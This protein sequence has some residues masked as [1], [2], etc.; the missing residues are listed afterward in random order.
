MPAGGSRIEEAAAG[1]AALAHVAGSEE[2]TS[3]AMGK[4][5][6]YAQMDELEQECT[7]EL[8]WTAKGWDAGDEEPF[9]KPWS[10][11]SE[12]EQDAATTLGFD[13]R[14]FAARETADT[15]QQLNGGNED[16]G[17][18]HEVSG[19]HHMKAEGP[20]SSPMP[21]IVAEEGVPPVLAPAGGEQPESSGGSVAVAD[22][23]GWDDWEEADSASSDVPAGDEMPLSP[24]MATLPTLL[25]SDECSSEEEPTADPG[26]GAANKMPATTEADSPGK[27]EAQT[28]G[29]ILRARREAEA[30]LSRGDYDAAEAAAERAEALL[31]TQQGQ[32]VVGSLVGHPMA[33]AAEGKATAKATATADAEEADSL[34]RLLAGYRKPGRAA[35]LARTSRQKRGALSVTAVEKLQ[36]WPAMEAAAAQKVVD[37]QELG[38]AYVAA[39]ASQPP[40]EALPGG[41]TADGG[42]GGGG[43]DLSSP[44][45]TVLQQL[46][47]HA[48]AH[49][50]EV[51]AQHQ[52]AAQAVAR[53]EAEAQGLVQEAQDRAARVLAGAEEAAERRS[54]A[55]GLALQT[56]AEALAEAERVS[57]EVEKTEQRARLVMFDARNQANDNMQQAGRQLAEA[58]QEADAVRAAAAAA[59]ASERSTAQQ[60]VMAVHEEAVAMLAARTEVAQAEAAA[61]S[62]QLRAEREAHEQELEAASQAEAAAHSAQLRAEREA[63]EQELEA[64]SQAE[65]AARSAR[66]R[67]EREAHDQELEA[68]KRAAE[69]EA[70]I[71]RAH[72]AVA[73]QEL[74]AERRR[75]AEQVSRLGVACMG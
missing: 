22:G 61:H 29:S 27:A 54:A 55:K 70:A 67:A 34:E 6:M 65:A 58:Q 5:K 74:Q 53:A 36:R 59:A 60:E 18:E 19:S 14:D 56:V 3:A 20:E 10:S 1:D 12:N 43:D 68:R 41:A 31:A 16:T 7:L 33:P 57:K 46:E 21:I 23:D 4:D 17:V 38:R 13:H 66:L 35:E 39:T 26:A 28:D 42:G 8:G 72:A 63:H 50:Q 69:Q 15:A 49:M 71:A 45:P 9:E 44:T 64:A 25:E 32:G 62:A 11:L 48:Q 30:F 40:M 75:H 47:E 2:A 52:A 51:R 73:A 37:V 24:R